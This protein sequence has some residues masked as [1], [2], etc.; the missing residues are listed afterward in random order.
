MK[1]KHKLY[2]CDH[3]HLCD[4]TTCHHRQPHEWIDECEDEYCEYGGA[5][6]N[7]SGIVGKVACLEYV[8]PRGKE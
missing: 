4:D 5:D 1:D 6:F 7:G 3:A 8:P 2:I